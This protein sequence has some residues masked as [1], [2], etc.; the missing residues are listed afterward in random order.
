M[1]VGKTWMG[2]AKIN[3]DCSF[4][5]C[6]DGFIIPGEI[7]I[8]V[9]YRRGGPDKG[10]YFY[11]PLHMTCAPGYFGDKYQEILTARRSAAKVAK[12]TRLSGFSD[13]EKLRRRRALQYIAWHKNRAL[14]ALGLRDGYRYEL[15][16]R[17]ILMRV[18]EI[19]NEIG[20]GEPKV[21][22]PGGKFYNL[23]HDIPYWKEIMVRSQAGTIDELNE[24]DFDKPGDTTMQ[25]E[26]EMPQWE[27]LTEGWTEKPKI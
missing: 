27:R 9:V 13:G 17:N 12:K 2:V 26:L 15:H 20:G 22:S 24:F 8:Q 19:R 1:W 14:D 23:E 10:A 5:G 7:H 4:K 25:P 18:Y 11:H 21:A 3:K 16:V 6:E